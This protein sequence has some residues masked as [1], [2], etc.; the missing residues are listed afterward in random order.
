MVPQ[1]LF[2]VPGVPVINVTMQSPT[3]LIVTN[4]GIETHFST[5]RYNVP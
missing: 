2:Y 1:L 5:V 3:F 4:K